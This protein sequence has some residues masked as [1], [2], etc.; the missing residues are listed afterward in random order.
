MD[1]N[2]DLCDAGAVLHQSSYQA[3]W[4]LIVL[5][6]DSKPIDIDL[7]L[8]FIHSASVVLKKGRIIHIHFNSQFKYMKIMY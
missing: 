1:S 6:V 8:K 2:P 5:W 7:H 3:N 4:E